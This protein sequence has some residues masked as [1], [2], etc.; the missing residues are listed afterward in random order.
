MASNEIQKL[1][2]L[3]EI[4]FIDDITFDEILEEMISDYESFYEEK[5]G[6]KITL[7][8]GDKEYIHIRIEAAQY[9]Q[10]YLKLD[11]S[12][13]MNL[14]KYS[15]GDFLKHLG[16][17]KKTF[18]D[19]PKAAIVTARFT[20]SGVR[21]DV[22]YIPAGTRIT[23][24]D[25]IYFETDEYA[26]I[27]AGAEYVDIPCTCQTV[28]TVG[29]DYIVGQIST[30][31]D[32]VPYVAAVSNITKSEGGTGEESEESFRERIFLAPSSYSTAGPADAYEYWVKQYNS[33]AI[34]DVKIHEPEEAIV[35][36]RIL[37][38][39]GEIPSQTFCDGAL[40]YLK[41][42]P[43]IPLTDNDQVAPPDI[44]NYKLKATYYIARSN[45]N[46]I[47]SIQESIEGAKET[48][49]NWQKTKIGRDINPDALTEF[50]RAA[51]GKRVAIESPVFTRI[52][53]TSIAIE[54]EVEFVYGGVEDD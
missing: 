12:A 19:Q 46:N 37:L 21:K 8:P 6:Q 44:V 28:G 39:G 3:P 42:N 17:F 23:A 9:Y 47:A 4:S 24:G 31:V 1:Y 53:E 27:S 25:A 11:N 26:E 14:L 40:A 16:A 22:I 35:D 52:P 2:D 33:A 38:K 36:I 50:V 10:M 49:L 54:S 15:K 48:Y 20:L 43:I 13:K 45:I 5:T 7:R 18:I 51:G 32:P 41:E 34:E 29:N 30:I